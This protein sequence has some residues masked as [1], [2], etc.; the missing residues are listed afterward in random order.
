MEKKYL[1]FIAILD[2]I[3]LELKLI[4]INFKN[5][6]ICYKYKVNEI[7]DYIKMEFRRNGQKKDKKESKKKFKKVI[8]G[9]DEICICPECGTRILNP[10]GLCEDETCPKCGNSMMIISKYQKTNLR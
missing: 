1:D 7:V 10:E 2:Q 8:E 4:S 6:H 3:F 5:Y 9:T